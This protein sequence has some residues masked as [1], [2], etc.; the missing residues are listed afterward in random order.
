MSLNALFIYWPLLAIAIATTLCR[1]I[2]QAKAADRA[3]GI[4]RPER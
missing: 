2:H 3:L 1:L 4:Q